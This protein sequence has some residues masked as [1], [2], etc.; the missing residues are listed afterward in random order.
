MSLQTWVNDPIILG[1]NQ[2]FFKGQKETPGMCV[3]LFFSC[4]PGDFMSLS[5]MA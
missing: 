3:Y 2:P 1:I 5:E 4:V